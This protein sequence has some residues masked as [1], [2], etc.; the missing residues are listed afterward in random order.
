M[1]VL[2]RGRLDMLIEG[3]ENGFHDV[4]EIPAP[5]PF[6]GGT[7]FRIAGIRYFWVECRRC[8]AAGEPSTDV[9]EAVTLWNMGKGIAGNGGP[10]PM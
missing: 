9:N 8:G 6:C 7:W 10:P 1:P 5:C 3:F 4:G 2:R